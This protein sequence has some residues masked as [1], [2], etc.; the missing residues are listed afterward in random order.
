M[1]NFNYKTENFFLEQNVDNEK[2]FINDFHHLMRFY[3]DWVSFKDETD[4]WFKESQWWLHE[5]CNCLYIFTEWEWKWFFDKFT[6]DED[7]RRLKLEIKAKNYQK[8][9]LDFSFHAKEY[10]LKRFL[11]KWIISKQYFAYLDRLDN[12]DWL[13]ELYFLL[14]RKKS[15][16]SVI[17][18]ANEEIVEQVKWLVAKILQEDPKNSFRRLKNLSVILDEIWKFSKWINKL[19]IWFKIDLNNL[20][21]EIDSWEY[22]NYVDKLN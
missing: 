13:K 3:F 22:V 15:A 11:E 6:R 8:F 2:E 1:T 16:E 14:N 10:Y 7:L 12:W 9:L 21:P 20:L 4:P 19:W 18:K 17:Q 5:A